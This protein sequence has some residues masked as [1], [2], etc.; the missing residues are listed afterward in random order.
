MP[1]TKR[2][3][4][5][6]EVSQAKK[7]RIEGSAQNASPKTSST[8]DTEKES[9]GVKDR[10][11][12]AP[13]EVE[14]STSEVTQAEKGKRKQINARRAD[15]NTSDAKSYKIRKLEPP[16]PFPTVPTSVS[17]TGPRSAHTEGKNYITVTRKTKLGAYLRRCKDVFIKDGYS[18][19]HI[20]L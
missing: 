9:E 12:R 4:D 13:Q 3:R 16:R 20:V 15:K 2:K 8:D 17:A 19:V 7:P 10:G 1:S 14:T 11:Q 6:E 18:L 5:V